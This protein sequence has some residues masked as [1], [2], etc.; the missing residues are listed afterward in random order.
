[1]AGVALGDIGLCFA[2]Q[3]WRS[4]RWAG[5]GRALGSAMVARGAASL[6][7]AG[8]PLGDIECRLVSCP[9]LNGVAWE[10]DF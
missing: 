1:V 10:A 5:S 8:V 2:W 6:C 3:A 4:Q 9:A 7:V